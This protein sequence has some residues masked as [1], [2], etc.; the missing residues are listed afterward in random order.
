M[1]YFSSCEVTVEQ[2]NFHRI[3]IFTHSTHF[4]MRVKMRAYFS[5]FFVFYLL[6]I[7]GFHNL[8]CRTI[9]LYFIKRK[10]NLKYIIYSTCSIK[11][12]QP[13]RTDVAF[14]RTVQLPDATAYLKLLIRTSCLHMHERCAL[15][16]R[17]CKKTQQ[18]ITPKKNLLKN[19]TIYTWRW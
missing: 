15:H 19:Q 11:K 9:I 7:H 10:L 13:L 2:I 3:V 5:F 16:L 4:P 6:S 14:S 17:N 1:K 18:I 8:W 12:W